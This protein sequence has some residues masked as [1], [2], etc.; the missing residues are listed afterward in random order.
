MLLKMKIEMPD[1]EE[2]EID[3]NE[4]DATSTIVNID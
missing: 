4:N 3:D 1:I 2:D